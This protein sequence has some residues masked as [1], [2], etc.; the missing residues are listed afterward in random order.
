[1]NLRHYSS[2]LRSP[3]QSAIRP[4]L[5]TALWLVSIMLPVSFITTLLQYTGL[6]EVVSVHL[7]PLCGLIGLRGESA[8]VLLTSAGMTLYSG[9][10]AM[11]AIPFTMREVTIMALMML[12]AHNMIVETAVQRKTGSR[13]LQ[14]VV[15][16][17]SGAIV[18]GMF[19]NAVLPE[20]NTVMMHGMVASNLPFAAVMKN[21]FTGSVFLTLM[22]T[23][24]V[25]CLNIFQRILTEFG[26]MDLSTRGMA[27][28]MKPMGLPSAVSFPWIISNVVGLA[29]GSSILIENRKNEHVSQKDSDLLNHH[30]ALSHSLVEDTLVFVAIGVPVFWITVPRIVLA[31]ISVWLIR[32][33]YSVIHKPPHPEETQRPEHN[34]AGK[35]KQDFC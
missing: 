34:Y 14:M 31:I 9:I 19:L 26:L 6:L 24:I 11:Q 22:I 12:V 20:D 15:L 30:I 25:V 5:R 8:L 23:C 7:H 21:W 18:S 32:G 29:Y 17:V 27:P 1:M 28:L 16:R 35:N 33:I 4:A 13:A 2:R 3:V 10:A